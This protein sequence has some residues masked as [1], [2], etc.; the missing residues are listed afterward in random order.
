LENVRRLCRR[1]GEAE[2]HTLGNGLK[3]CLLSQ[4]Q[5][6]V[7]TTVLS[8]RAGTRDETPGYGGAAHFLEHM[9]FKG[10]ASYGPGEIDRRTQALGGSNNAFTSHDGTVYYFN[11]ARDRYR[12]GLAIEADRM[13]ALTLDPREVDAERQVILEE[14][15]MY[16]SDPWDALDQRVQQRLFPGHPYGL[17]VLGTPEDLERTD[18]AALGDFHH[19]F[20]RPGNAVLVL[21]GDLEPGALEAVEEAFGALPDVTPEPPDLAPAAAGRPDGLVRFERRMGEVPRLLLSLPV[22]PGD[23]DELP[24]IRSLVSVLGDGRSARLQRSLVDEQQ[25]A[26]SLSVYASES[27]DPGHLSI[28]VEAAPGI[29]PERVEEALWAEL[30]RLRDE[31]VG[32]LELERARRVQVADWVFDHERIHQQALAAAFGLTFYDLDHAER[33]LCRV[34]EVTAEELRDAARRFLDPERGAVLGWSL[35]GQ[36]EQER[37]EAAA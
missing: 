22:P 2:V 25:V 24:A 19:R 11:F 1:P 20:Y 21:A 8:Y 29:E 17:P 36:A 4:P 23:S 33:Q 35:P 14:I 31:P 30:A 6:P 28:L 18:A 3:V 16:E 12:E 7:V 26:S 34:L 5:A 9:M 10:S 15:S 37:A 27:L 32:P 13:A